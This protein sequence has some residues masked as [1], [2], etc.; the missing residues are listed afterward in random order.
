MRDRIVQQA[1]YAGLL[2]LGAGPNTLRL[3]SQ[4]TIHRDLA[5]FA[6]ETL[7]GLLAAG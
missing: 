4:L 1:F 7:E 6:M 3:C 5:D 2:I